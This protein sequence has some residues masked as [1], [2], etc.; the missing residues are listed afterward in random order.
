MKYLPGIPVAAS[1]SWM[2]AAI[3]CAIGLASSCSGGGGA[4]STDG[5]ATVPDEDF[6]GLWRGSWASSSLAEGEFSISLTQLSGVVSGP[7]DKLGPA[8]FD[9]GAIDGLVAGEL[10]SGTCLDANH[11]LAFDLEMMPNQPNGDSL[12]NGTFIVTRGMCLGETG[13]IQAERMNTG[14]TLELFGKGKGADIITPKAVAWPIYEDEEQVILFTLP[15]ERHFG[16]SEQ[17]R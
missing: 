3:L 15:V 5:G 16:A 12:L 8:C 6:S 9:Q 10:L 1:H 7:A 13:T 11:E 2:T 14:M 4:A 17:N